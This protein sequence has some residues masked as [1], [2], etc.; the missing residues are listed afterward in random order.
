MPSA[1]FIDAEFR[2]FNDAPQRTDG[3]RFVAVVPPDHL[4][5]V[6]VSPFLMTALLS[7]LFK[8]ITPQD[9]NDIVRVADWIALTHQTVSSTSLADSPKGISLGSNQSSSASLALAMASSS[10]SPAEA[11]PGSSGKTDE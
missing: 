9:T 3:N 11:Q 2:T 8:T 7:N 1:E 4:P 10:V 5:T 6:S